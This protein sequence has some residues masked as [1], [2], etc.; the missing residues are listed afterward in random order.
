MLL[1]QALPRR[2]RDTK[3]SNPSYWGTFNAKAQSKKKNA[4]RNIKLLVFAL[5]KMI[6]F[7]LGLPFAPLRL[8]VKET[9]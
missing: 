5:L 7:A 1:E 3:K 6:F 9:A 4:K 2:L 8:C